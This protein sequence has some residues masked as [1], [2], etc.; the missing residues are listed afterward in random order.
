MPFHKKIFKKAKSTAKRATRSVSRFGK[1]STASAGKFV[2]RRAKRA[3]ATV[4]KVQRRS[5]R[6]VAKNVRKATRGVTRGASKIGKRVGKVRV[7]T[8]VSK[9]PFTSVFKGAKKGLRRINPFRTVRGRL[10]A[11]FRRARR[12]RPRR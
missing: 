12:G 8:N 4:G 3:G 10:G 6:F 7:G 5:D 2:A 9:G 1:R 11:R